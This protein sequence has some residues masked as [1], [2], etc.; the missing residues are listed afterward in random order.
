[1]FGFGVFSTKDTHF[2]WETYRQYIKYI[3]KRSDYRRF[4]VHISSRKRNRA[5]WSLSSITWKLQ[6]TPK[7]LNLREKSIFFGKLREKSTWF[8]FGEFSTKITDFRWETYRQD[9]KYIQ[10]GSHYRKCQ[11]Q[12]WSKKKTTGFW[13]LTFSSFTIKFTIFVQIWIRFYLWLSSSG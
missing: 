7:S 11:V 13:S 4:Q 6:S 2:R 9:I 10:K 12:I 3:S 1:M 5:L 8:G